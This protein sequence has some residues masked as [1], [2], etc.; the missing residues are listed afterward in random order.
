MTSRHVIEVDRFL[1]HPPGRVW[2]ALT[3][4][5]LLSRWLMP[6]SFQPHVGHVFTLDA[7][8]H[9]LTTCEVLAVEPERLLRISWR[10]PP[11]DT[12]VTFRLEAEGSGTRLFIEHRGFDESDPAQCAA[13]D[14]ML[15][16][17]RSGILPVLD[18]VVSA[19]FG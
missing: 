10:N 16:G 9:G 12:T 3:D 15:P 6:T 13:Y 18:A 14:A 2:L 19:E 8:E 17:W 1:R 4:S 7:G 5:N 11:L